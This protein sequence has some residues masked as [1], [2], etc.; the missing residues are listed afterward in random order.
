MTSCI[1]C[2]FSSK[3]RT[4]CVFVNIQIYYTSYSVLFMQL[5]E[6]LS[7]VKFLSPYNYHFTHANIQTDS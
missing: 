5:C 6:K 3:W 7:W 2:L 1:Q 4:T